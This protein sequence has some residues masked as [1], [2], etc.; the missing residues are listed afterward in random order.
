MLSTLFSRE[1]VLFQLELLDPSNCRTCSCHSKGCIASGVHPFFTR[2]LMVTQVEFH[3]VACT[4]QPAVHRGGFVDSWPGMLRCNSS[5][6]VRW[7]KEHHPVSCGF[8]SCSNFTKSIL[9]EFPGSVLKWWRMD[10][11][12][13]FYCNTSTFQLIWVQNSSMWPR[14]L[15]MCLWKNILKPVWFLK[16]M[17]TDTVWGT[18]KRQY[19]HLTTS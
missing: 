13:Q 16:P 2:F 7:F 19:P 3:F 10:N 17:N 4:L 8:G 6:F 5:G 12:W 1:D 14:C 18:T 15:N 11:S 9:R